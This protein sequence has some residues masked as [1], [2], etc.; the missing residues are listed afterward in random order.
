MSDWHGREQYEYAPLCRHSSQFC[1]VQ[2]APTGT[3][4]VFES[5]PQLFELQSESELHAPPTATRASHPVPGTQRMLLGH[6]DVQTSQRDA[7]AF[8][9]QISAPF[10]QT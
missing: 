4:H 9:H 1:P 7:G 5:A 6:T 10:W 3:R 2:L 8:G